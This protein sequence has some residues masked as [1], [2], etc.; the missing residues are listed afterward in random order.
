M[1]DLYEV[2]KESISSADMVLVGIGE[3]LEET[4]QGISQNLQDKELWEKELLKNQ[5]I[6]KCDCSNHIKAYDHLNDLLKDKNY[7]IVTICK[8]GYIYQS[9]LNK[10]RIVAPCGGYQKMQCDKGCNE[11]LFDTAIYQKQL[12]KALADRDI[13]MRPKCPKC[14]E[15]LMFNNICAEK[16]IEKDYMPQ[17][18]KYTKW[19]QGTINRKVCIL[20]L[21]AGLVFPNIIRWPFEKVA[22]YNNKAQYFR[23]HSVLGELTKEIQEKGY[24]CNENAFEFLLHM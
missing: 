20:E 24:S 2:L 19:L 17:W 11:E 4:F 12:E 16:Y 3:E 18:E 14:G 8:D 22:F 10:D 1:S 15:F 9:E 6:Q 7:F 5:Y 13:N 23:V 21:G